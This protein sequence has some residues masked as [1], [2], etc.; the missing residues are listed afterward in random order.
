[1]ASQ[2]S[3]ISYICLLPGLHYSDRRIFGAGE[4]A[5]FGHWAS[6]CPFSQLSFW[7][8]LFF[9]LRCCIDGF[10]SWKVSVLGHKRT[11]RSATRTTTKSLAPAAG[12]GLQGF[13]SSCSVLMHQVPVL[14]CQA[15][16]LFLT[17]SGAPHFSAGSAQLNPSVCPV[18]TSNCLC[19]ISLLILTDG[20]KYNTILE[21]S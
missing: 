10:L 2:A 17:P 18:A 7:L 16:G 13:L 20:Q 21:G 14:V 11:L 4:A 8:C 1:M 3:R 19:L 9:L 6:L 15:Q 12:E 5:D